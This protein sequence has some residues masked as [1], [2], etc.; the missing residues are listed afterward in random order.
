MLLQ[1]ALL[2]FLVALIFVSSVCYSE[3]VNVVPS[4]N[5]LSV[6]YHAEERPGFCGP[7]S[8]QMVLEYISGNAT[9]Q[10]VLARDMK[11]SKITSRHNLV[12]PFWFRGYNLVG[13]Q[14]AGVDDL[15]D[16]SSR[17]HVSVILIWFDTN[18]RGG[19][20]VVVTGYNETGIIVNDPYPPPPSSRPQPRS[21][22]TG[23]NA[24]ISYSLLDNLW[25]YSHQ[26]VL[27]V[28]YPNRLAMQSAQ[29][30]TASKEN[31]LLIYLAICSGLTVSLTAILIVLVRRHKRAT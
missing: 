16:W 4:S 8:V 1:R 7:T 30:T 11:T 5:L 29:I 24:F 27:E 2:F 25:A 3:Q 28:P 14:Y 6:P 9:E 12:L 10:N 31:S 26:W 13:E 15:K 19:H 18:H 21:R 22:R 23:M 20:Y 17:G